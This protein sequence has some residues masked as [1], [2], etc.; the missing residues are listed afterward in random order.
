MIILKTIIVKLIA[1]LLPDVMS[2]SFANGQNYNIFTF[3][4]V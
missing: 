3:M 1:V 4:N 2:K